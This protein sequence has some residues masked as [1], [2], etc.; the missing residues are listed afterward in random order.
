MKCKWVGSDRPRVIAGRH[1]ED[2]PGDC[3]GCQPC[4]RAHCG[5]CSREHVEDAFHCPECVGA[6][7][8]DLNGITKMCRDLPTEATHRGVNSEAA[9]LIGPAADP[10]TWGNRRM[11]A[12]QGRID[13]AWL[14]DCR[15]EQHPLWVLG[16]WDMLLAEHYGHDRTT[17]V[18]VVSAAG[19]LAANLTELAGDADFAFEEL[20]RDLRACRA[21]LEDV[22]HDSQREVT[23]AP[24]VQCH[25]PIVKSQDETGRETYRCRRCHRDLTDS[26]YKYAVKQAHLAHAS[27]LSADQMAERLEIPAS[28]VRRWA[29][30]VRQPVKAG[31]VAGAWFEGTIIEHP[32]LLRS[33]GTDADGRKVYR[34]SE[35]QRIAAIG[36]TRPR[37]PLDAAGYL[38]VVQVP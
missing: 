23:G 24:C 7:R 14:E 36:D 1:D 12:I 18:T 32:P 11:S 35:A 29:N 21:H 5:T 6:V 15:D 10:E 3:S 13:A 30:I 2:C 20:A 4:T 8:D 31:W 28:T 16:T 19:Y 17:R 37:T 9:M 38:Q 22:L 33:C 25:T 34:V 27:R 26:E